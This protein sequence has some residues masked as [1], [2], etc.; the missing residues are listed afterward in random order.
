M[1]LGTLALASLALVFGYLAARKYARTAAALPPGVIPRPEFRAPHAATS[2]EA[3]M[4]GLRAF[5]AE[6]KATFQHERCTRA[7]IMGLHSLRDEVLTHM[8]DMRMRLPNDMEAETRLTQ[9][10]E[11][12]DALLKRYL[13]DAM[14]RCGEGGALLFPGPLDD[15]FYRQFNRAHNDAMH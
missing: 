1:H 5:A 8:Y 2:Y 6:Y 11:D 13:Q 4:S 15:T 12:T 3:A 14:T 9:Y 7:A 10:I